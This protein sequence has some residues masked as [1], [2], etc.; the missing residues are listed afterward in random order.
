MCV[1]FVALVAI[2]GIA[3]ATGLTAIFV[4]GYKLCDTGEPPSEPGDLVAEVNEQIT[5]LHAL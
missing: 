4:G 5:R 1:E 3:L 2:R